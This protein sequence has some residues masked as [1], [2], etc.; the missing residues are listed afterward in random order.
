MGLVT[1]HLFFISGL[2][3]FAAYT[4]NKLLNLFR[5]IEKEI[6]AHQASNES[7]KPQFD[8]ETTA[9]VASASAKRALE[10]DTLPKKDGN[11]G[12]SSTATAGPT[13]M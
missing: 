11:H 8:M 12:N 2:W 3:F 7:E 5:G 10:V 9:R 13:E 6:L 1:F 4:S